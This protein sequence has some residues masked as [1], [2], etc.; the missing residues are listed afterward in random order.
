MKAAVLEKL[1]CLTVREVAEPAPGR[2]SVLV[3][4]EVCSVCG[5][6]L[7]MYRRGHPRVR[8][9]QVLGHEISGVIEAVGE[10]VSAWKTGDRVSITPKIAC[11]HCF[12]CLKGLYTYCHNGRSFGYQLPGGYAERLLVPSRGVE[13]GV[14]N[15]IGDS[16][17][18]E[19]ISLAEPLA[20][21]VRAQRKSTVSPGDAVVVIG[22]GPMGLLHCRLA[23]VNGAEKVI[24]I[25]RRPERL[26]RVSTAAIDRIADSRRS[27]P[28][29]E[30]LELTQGRGADV[31]IV[32]C[33][34]REAQEEAFSFVGRGGRVNFFGGL[35]EEQPHISMD[36]NLVHYCE[37]SVQ[38]S[39]GS[40]P[41]ENKEAVALLVRGTVQVKDLITHIYPLDSIEEAFRFAERKE[42][43]K[44][45]IHP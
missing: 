13:F 44:V 5:S 8:L 42:G 34:T 40:T 4:V 26:E 21:C 39:H 14:L 45:A 30:V 24:L 36:S 11:G 31:V 12:Y 2:G 17:S 28:I 38:G 27:R 33:S 22:D 19:E 16:L 3:K 35:P 23:R 1:Q 7:R 25:G 15:H 43:M 41:E 9:P 37:V 18:F 6:D 32:A 29:D 10:D 20:C